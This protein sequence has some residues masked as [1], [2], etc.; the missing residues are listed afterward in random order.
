MQNA[1]DKSR[2]TLA[3]LPP[4]PAGICPRC[5]TPIAPTE[6]VRFERGEVF[7]MKCG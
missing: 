6:S 3:G 2:E 1:I 7:H 4:A 5:S